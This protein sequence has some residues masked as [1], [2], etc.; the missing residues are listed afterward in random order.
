MTVCQAAVPFG[1]TWDA[2]GIVF[3]QGGGGIMRCPASGGAPEQLAS[4]NADEQAHGP[5]LLPDGEHLLF[6][7]AKQLDAARGIELQIVV[8][9]L[10][11]GERKT[12]INGGSDGRYLPSGHLLY[13]VGGVMLAVPFDLRRL[14]P[15][16]SAVP[17]LEGV[18]GRAARDR[19][20][21]TSPS[22]RRERCSM[23]L[24]PS[25]RRPTHVS[26]PSPIA[27]GSSRLS[28]C[29]SGRTCTC[30]LRRDGKHVA[31]GSDDGKEAI[32]W[33]YEL[34]GTSAI[35]RLTLD[36]HN[37]FPIW[38]PD[39][40]RVAF[41]ADRE[42]DLA[43]F[44]MRA[45]GTGA[46]ERLT[47]PGKGD[48]HVPGSWSPDGKHLAFSLQSERPRFSLH[49][50]SIDDKKTTPYGNVESAESSRT[51]VFARR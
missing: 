18:A 23:S 38:A 35:R 20:R 4:V 8:Q 40:Q 41:Q 2:S 16:G 45:D 10:K 31:L 49:M 27:L 30:A 29:Q 42:G 7:I 22:H 50:L 5:Q 51:R 48:S 6:T 24:A 44:A 1:V 15:T 3:G 36:G 37:R 13:A 46:M 47:K 26:W 28:R 34:A 32:I 39:G 17:V 33:I 21:L 12:V 11:S 25:V 43:I 9:N 19:G 14:Q